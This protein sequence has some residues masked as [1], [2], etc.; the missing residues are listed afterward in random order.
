MPGYMMHLCEAAY[1]ENIILNSDKGDVDTVIS[2][3]L[4]S[5]FNSPDSISSR[6]S[7]SRC[8]VGQIPYTLPSTM[9]GQSDH[10]I[11]QHALPDR[12]A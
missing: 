2:R 3:A 1:I 8:G 9:A 5:V 6:H 12:A 7:P 11:P 4:I 10:Q